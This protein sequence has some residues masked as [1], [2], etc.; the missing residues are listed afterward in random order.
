VWFQFGFCAHADSMHAN[1]QSFDDGSLMAHA[2]SGLVKSP[3]SHSASPM[4][5]PEGGAGSRSTTDDVDEDGALNAVA[6]ELGVGGAVGVVA[7]PH[8]SRDPNQSIGR[9]LMKAP[10]NQQGVRSSEAGRSICMTRFFFAVCSAVA[11]ALACGGTSPATH[12]ARRADECVETLAEH[13]KGPCTLTYDAEVQHVREGIKKGDVRTAEIG[14]CG[15]Y[16]YVV[17]TAMGSA[18]YFFDASGALVG[19]ATSGDAPVPRCGN[20][21]FASGFGAQPQCKR[22]TSESLKAD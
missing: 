5:L 17:E 9:R 21:T 4:H 20:D 13:C 6:D 19:G 15:D 2:T 22:Q 11:V 16:R 8:A 7:V 12:N 18:S 1:G 3:K 14:A 10:Y